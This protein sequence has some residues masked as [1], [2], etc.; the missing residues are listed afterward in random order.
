[1]RTFEERYTAWI[2][3]QLEGS[4]LTAF[5]LE[6]SR[7]AS[8]GEA[9]ADKTAAD[10]LRHLL[11]THLRAPAMTNTDFFSHQLR[12]RIEADRRI[13]ER[14]RGTPHAERKPLFVWSFGQLVGLGSAFLFVSAALYYGL[15]P[16]RTG[17]MEQVAKT[18]ASPAANVALAANDSVTPVP[19]ATSPSAGPR[20][21]AQPLELANRSPLPPA[22]DEAPEDIQKVQVPEQSTPTTATPLHY[23]KQDVNVIWINGLDYM[24]S[25]PGEAAAATAVPQP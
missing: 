20:D 3:G 6:L 14:R 8:A 2:D 5:E 12:E 21:P 22:I 17:P 9:L 4:A 16:P 18:A 19:Q 11:A 7:R 13:A 1:M 23:Q 15:M 25:V 10:H 24:P